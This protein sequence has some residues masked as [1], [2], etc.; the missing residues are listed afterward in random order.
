MG[1]ITEAVFQAIDEHGLTNVE[2]W[3]GV[4]NHHRRR[5]EMADQSST[6][7]RALRVRAAAMQQN[8]ERA[9]RPSS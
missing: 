8:L 4:I 7:V 9:W 5:V 6:R 2:D 1:N 3:N